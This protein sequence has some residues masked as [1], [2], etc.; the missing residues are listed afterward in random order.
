M[1]AGTVTNTYTVIGYY[2]EDDS[3]QVAGVV[4]GDHEVTG[5]DDEHCQPWATVVEADDVLAAQA[6]ARAE[7]TAANGWEDEDQ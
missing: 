6:A 5:G 2:A 4:D 7:M 3:V 1:G